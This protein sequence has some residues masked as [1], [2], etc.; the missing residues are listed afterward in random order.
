MPT[1]SNQLQ[2]SYNRTRVFRR[3]M[4]VVFFS[5]F[6]AVV[7]WAIPWLPYGLA[8]EDYN[9]RLTLLMLLVLAASVSAF[10]AVYMRDLSD[11]MEQTVLTWATVHDGLSDMRRREY[12]YDRIVAECENTHTPDTNQFTVVALRMEKAPEGDEAAS[13]EKAMEQV[14]NTITDTDF[15]AI[16]GPHEIGVM[17]LRTGFAEAAAFAERLRS[18]L[19]SSLQDG[20]GVR[21]GWSV[22]PQDGNEAAVL[23]GIARE[24]LWPVGANRKVVPVPDPQDASHRA[25]V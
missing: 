19:A 4:L 24:R 10:G 21:A 1:R 3:F 23:L 15:L 25:A 14:G 5:I 11:R 12:F 13:M 18:H 6:V 2:R 22:Y 17:S 8:V 20:S 9:D 16:L 7:L